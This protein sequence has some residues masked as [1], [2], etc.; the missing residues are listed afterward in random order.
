MGLIRM[1]QF[2]VGDDCG[3]FR[4]V[5]DCGASNKYTDRDGPRQAA[6]DAIK[7]AKECLKSR[8]IKEGTDVWGTDEDYDAENY[9]SEHIS[10]TVLC[11]ADFQA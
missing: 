10:V 2:K 7:H 11:Y 6:T 3:T 1:P 9:L 5:C 8:R 4:W